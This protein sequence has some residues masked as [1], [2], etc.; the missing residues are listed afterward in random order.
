MGRERSLLHRRRHGRTNCPRLCDAPSSHLRPLA[1]GGDRA[2]RR[3]RHSPPEG[4]HERTLGRHRRAS[5]LRPRERPL[6]HTGRR[7]GHRGLQVRLRSPLRL[8]TRPR[9]VRSSRR[10]RPCPASRTWRRRSTTPHGSPPTDT[11]RSHR[12]TSLLT[13]HS[14]RSA[15]TPLSRCRR[16]PSTHRSRSPSEATRSSRATCRQPSSSASSPRS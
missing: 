8:R 1:R 13:T 12:S 2:H 10:S 7:V 11:S 3:G 5:G 15:R 14:S 16:S 6:A 4:G 9:S